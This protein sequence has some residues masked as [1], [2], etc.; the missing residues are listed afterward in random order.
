MSGKKE[1]ARCGLAVRHPV[2]LVLLL[3]LTLSGAGFVACGPVPMPE[4][5]KEASP[6]DG[7]KVIPTEPPSERP[8]V[9]T[10]PGVEPSTPGEDAPAEPQRPDAGPSPDTAIKDAGTVE[11]EPQDAPDTGTPEVITR[12]QVLTPSSINPATFKTQ[13]WNLPNVLKNETHLMM[14]I[15]KKTTFVVGSARGFWKLNPK[16]LQRIDSDP[17]VGLVSWQDTDIVVANKKGLFLWDGESFSPT[18]F[19][20]NLKGANITALAAK[21]QNAFWIGT[22]KALWL[23][24]KDKLHEFSGVTDVASLTYSAPQK[25]LVIRD[26]MEHYSALRQDSSGAWI[27]RSFDSE[28]HK[29]MT[30]SPD[31]QTLA[32]FW[33]LRPQDKSLLYRKVDGINASWWLF[34][35][36]PDPKD[37]TIETLNLLQ[38]LLQQH[39]TNLA[40]GAKPSSYTWALTGE[41]LYRLSEGITLHFKKPATLKSLIAATSTDDGAVWVSDGEKLTRI[42]AST[43]PTPPVLTYSKDIKPFVS[44]YCTTCHAPAPTGNGQTPNLSTYNQVKAKMN[45][46]KRR[47]NDLVKPMPP[48]YAKQFPTKAEIL[49]FELWILGGAKQ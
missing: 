35:I 37:D 29:L 49:D 11:K 6:T 3:S 21:D 7:G 22:D 2:L 42:D 48:S 14:A 27:L 18:N 34:R 43:A 9:R 15:H 33:G 31:N 26:S 10:E 4:G 16:N 38:V 41:G 47:M 8:I 40:A 23:Y 44:K 32:Q 24:E 30:V 12:Q 39:T 17:V 5:Q 13:M 19:L 36:K 28:G 45:D 25:V 20:K 1:E 46:M